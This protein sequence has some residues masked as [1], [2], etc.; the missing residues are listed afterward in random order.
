MRAGPLLADLP[1]EPDGY[2]AD[3]V[4]GADAHRIEI[5]ELLARFSQRWSVER[6]PVVDRALLRLAVY[7]LGW[8]PDVPT[9]VVIDEAVDLARQYSTEDSPRFV[10]GLLGAVATELRGD[11]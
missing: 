2:A 5:D 6:M 8:R 7:E 10:N 1:V 9:A 3:L 4:R 11:P